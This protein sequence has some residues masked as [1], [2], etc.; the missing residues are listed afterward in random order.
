MLV[1]IVGTRP[2]FVKLASIVR[3]AR[4]QNLDHQ[5]IHTGQ[6]YDYELSQV[7]FEQLQIP[8]P[9]AHLEVG[10]GDDAYQIGETIQRS[11][12][13]LKSLRRTAVV[14][15][16]GDANATVGGALGA[17]KTGFVVGHVESGIRTGDYRLPEELNRILA[18][19]CADI[20]F[21]PTQHTYQNI[22][23]TG[24]GVLV[25]DVMYDTL[26]WVKPRLSDTPLADYGLTMGQYCVVTLHRNINVDDA[27]TLGRIF[28]ILAGTDEHFVFPVHPRTQKTLKC[29]RVPHN[30][31]LL[32]PLGYLPF[33]NLLRNAR[34]VITDS[35]GVQKDAY[36]FGVPCITLLDAQIWPETTKAGWN[37]CVGLD[38][39]RMVQAIKSFW[40]KKPRP[41]IFGDGHAAESIIGTLQNRFKASLNG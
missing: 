3:A 35:G 7:F 10:S 14:L 1:S 34:K 19:A 33:L 5:I 4:D 13:V 32:P 30:I 23:V 17:K 40:P 36:T 16:Y 6:H 9:D 12:K 28:K 18:E 11:A 2:N 41:P 15:V 26:L 39:H 31:Q 25:G 22:K 29:L 38:S 37:L 27:S 24:R 20:L 8:P 21:A